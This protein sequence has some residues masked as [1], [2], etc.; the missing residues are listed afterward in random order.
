MCG[1]YA[2]SNQKQKLNY[3]NSV[4]LEPVLTEEEGETQTM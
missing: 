1:A 4:E 3:Y 2:R